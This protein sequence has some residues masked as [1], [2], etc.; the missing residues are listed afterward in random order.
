MNINDITGWMGSPLNFGGY[1]DTLAGVSY[2]NGI[3][4]DGMDPNAQAQLTLRN[5]G[6]GMLANSNRNPMQALGMSYLQAQNQGLD[7]ARQTMVAKEF[8]ANEEDRKLKKQ[9]FDTQQEN[10]KRVMQMLGYPS[11]SGGMTSGAPGSAAPDQAGTP[12]SLEKLYKAKALYQAN[13]DEDSAQAIDAM[14]TQIERKT[15]NENS[16]ATLDMKRQELEYNQ[17]QKPTIESENDL[18]KYYTEKGIADDRAAADT[19]NTV[20][21]AKAVLES[22]NFESGS[23]EP[24]KLALVSMGKALGFEV[25]EEYLTDGQYYRNLIMNVVIP[26]LK[27]IGGNDS[28]QEMQELKAASGGDITQSKKALLNTLGLIERLSLGKYDGNKWMRETVRKRFPDFQ[29]PQIN[30]TKRRAKVIAVE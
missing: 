29:D 12:L 8:K 23:L 2:P 6:A 16:Q 9:A 14:I 13:G 4:P 10:R 5:M 28:N 26:R 19:I 11:E 18:V 30:P 27:A 7:N 17:N 22:G 25:N 15:D 1:T 24:Q 20:R 3:A 21:E